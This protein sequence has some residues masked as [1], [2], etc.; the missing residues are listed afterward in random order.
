M[1]DYKEIFKEEVIQA[2][3]NGLI[4]GGMSRTHAEIYK[5][6]FDR[7]YD[8]GFNECRRRLDTP[9]QVYREAITKI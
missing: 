6:L 8:A 5:V 9:D 4:Q 2:A 7:I 3:V 1:M